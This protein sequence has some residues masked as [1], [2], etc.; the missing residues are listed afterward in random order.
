[1]NG[2]YCGYWQK[3]QVSKKASI[4]FRTEGQDQSSTPAVESDAVPQLSWGANI[5][6]LA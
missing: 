4:G 6:F 2:R 5:K 3:L 1:V